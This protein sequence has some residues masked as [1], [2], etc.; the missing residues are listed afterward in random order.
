MQIF[1][2]AFPSLCPDEFHDSR[3]CPSLRCRWSRFLFSYVL[4]LVVG[5]LQVV[6]SWA[7]ETP[8]SEQQEIPSSSDAMQPEDGGRLVLGSI[9]EPSNLIP[10]ISTDSASADVAGLIYVA[11]LRYGKDLKLEPWAAESWVASDDG[12][13]L[14]FTLRKGI[15]WED[16]VELTA[17]DV[18]F[19]CRAVT[20]PKNGSPYAEDYLRI[21]TIRALDRYR[22]EVTYDSYYAR[23]EASF[24]SA[25][26]PKHLLEGQNLRSTALAR[27]PVGAGAYR[28]E[29][30]EPGNR[31]VLKARP[32]YF[33]GRPHIDEIVYRIIPDSATMFMELRAGR[34]D[35]MGLSP[36]QYLRQTDS[37]WWKQNFS[38]YRM[39]SSVYVYLGFNLEHP[40]FKD[41]KVRL[42]I[43]Q[44]ISRDEIIKGA[45]MGEGVPAFG[46]YKP[47]T[48]FYHP[49]LKPMKQDLAEAKRLL[50]E[51][52]FKDTDGD[53]ILDREGKPFA[54]TILTNQGNSE[55]ILVAIIIQSQLAKLG[56]KV[57][58]R[59]VEWAAFIREF[60][61][62]GLFDAVI[63]GWTIS[64][65]PDLYQVWHSSQAVAGGLNFTHFKNAEL[66]KLLD[67][68]RR[69]AQKDLR[70][71]IYRHIQEIL[72]REQPYCFLYVP[73]SL[74]IVQRRFRGIEPALAG[75]TW[76]LENWW[77]PRSEQRSFSKQ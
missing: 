70:L 54:F 30:W 72:A 9:G 40:F 27:K 42:A 5:T 31:L 23:A 4:L 33:L 13:R 26:L 16:G 46:P 51:A 63:L 59:T 3:I 15:F 64:P 6:S 73:Y 10:Y 61:H 20:D 35:L 17:D 41:R 67:E 24:A 48:E 2:N 60:V 76:N 74:S 57:Q 68:G 49:T 12:C 47:G 56:I 62:K 58:V 77:V 18:V 69:T 36:E 52:G 71:D 38:K 37:Q 1:I 21:K 7:V 32:G 22:F 43:S 50:A 8:H 34:V 45:L 39:L 28:L 25:I 44:A 14:V 11:P 19:T 66:D 75:I 29:S 55:R 65:D 53:G